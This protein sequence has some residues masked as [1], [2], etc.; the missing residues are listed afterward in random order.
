MARV[1]FF[2]ERGSGRLY[3]NEV[4]TIPGFTKISM[5]PKMWGASGISYRELVDR[6][7]TLALERH[8]QRTALCTR[9]TP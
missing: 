9:Y 3:V 7:I 4:N 1:D 5:Y 8:R 6:L 2:L